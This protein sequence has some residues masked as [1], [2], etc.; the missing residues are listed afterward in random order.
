MAN[1]LKNIT[2]YSKARDIVQR[3]M[4]GNSNLNHVQSADKYIACPVAQTIQSATNAAPINHVS[5]AAN[6]TTLLV[7]SPN[8]VSYAIHAPTISGRK[9]H[10]ADVET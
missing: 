9:K 2:V 4:R 8:M 3:A 10:V 5:D 1:L 6:R 7:K